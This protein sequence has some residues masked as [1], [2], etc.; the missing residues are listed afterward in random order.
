M[1]WGILALQSKDILINDY[2]FS[3]SLLHGVWI[4]YIVG[5]RSNS[6]PHEPAKLMNTVAVLPPSISLL[7][8]VL[9]QEFKNQKQPEAASFS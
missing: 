4:V 5:Y 3:S 7:H 1:F 6:L 9:I 2:W 8:A